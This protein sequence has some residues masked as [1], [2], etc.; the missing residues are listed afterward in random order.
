[1][2]AGR[3]SSFTCFASSARAFRVP[4]GVALTLF[5][6]YVGSTT[7]IA[8]FSCTEH[9]LDTDY[10]SSP[11]GYQLVRNVHN[12]LVLDVEIANPSSGSHGQ[13]AWVEIWWRRAVSPPP[14]T[15]TFSD[16]PPSSPVQVR[17]G[18]PLR[19]NHRRLRRWELLP[20]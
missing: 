8:T 15:A 14:A 13:L 19:R 17:R 16:V 20:R 9:E 6:R 5:G 4:T 1:M 18:A 11:I 12:M 3:S 10:N 2:N 7:T